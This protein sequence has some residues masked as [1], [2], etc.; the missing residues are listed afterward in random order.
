LKLS[1]FK[2]KAAFLLSICGP[3][4]F[5]TGIIYFYCFLIQF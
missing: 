4:E 5:V 2:N 1:K 3:S